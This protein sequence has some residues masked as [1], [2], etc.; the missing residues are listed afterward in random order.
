MAGV[1]K[2]QSART[3]G[4][5]SSVGEPQLSPSAATAR[6]PAQTDEPAGQSPT[7]HPKNVPPREP[8]PNQ[9]SKYPMNSTTLNATSTGTY[10]VV[11]RNASLTGR[12]PRHGHAVGLPTHSSTQRSAGASGSRGG[13]RPFPARRREAPPQPK[14]RTPTLRAAHRTVH[15]RRGIAEPAESNHQHLIQQRLTVM[16]ASPR[17]ARQERMTEM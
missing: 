10:P 8:H 11:G 2:E 7:Q 5:G 17:A 4:F 16:V 3:A 14:G 1:S 13:L 15:P 9:M 6:T 12:A